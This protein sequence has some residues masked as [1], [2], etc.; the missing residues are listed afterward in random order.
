MSDE[1]GARDLQGVEEEKL[2]VA[3][4]VVAEVRV[5][6]ELC[7]GGGECLAESHRSERFPSGSSD[8]SKDV[9][10]GVGDGEGGTVFDC[11]DSFFVEMAARP[12]RDSR[13]RGVR[14]ALVPKVAVTISTSWPD[15]PGMCMVIWSPAMGL[16]WSW[17]M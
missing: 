12:C 13:F 16:K 3:G 2:C 8:S 9:A 6:G 7:G 5:G 11:G 15:S 10:V 17:L 1:G 4:R 14:P